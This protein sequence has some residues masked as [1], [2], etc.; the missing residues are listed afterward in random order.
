MKNIFCILLLVISAFQI[1]AE[2]IISNETLFSI[3]NEAYKNEAYSDALESYQELMDNGKSSFELYYNTGNCHF[4]LGN[5]VEAVW[6]YEMAKRITPNN[7][8]VQANIALV[9]RQFVD[10]IKALPGIPLSIW[11]NGFI[12][13]NGANFW[14]ALSLLS[15][16]GCILF[17]ISLWINNPVKY[18]LKYLSLAT[19]IVGLFSFFIAMAV[20]HHFENAQDAI[21][22][23][24]NADVLSEPSSNALELFT[25]HAG[26]K[27]EVLEQNKNWSRIK[28]ASGELGWMKNEEMRLVQ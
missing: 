21:L 6:H 24:S 19:V 2:D 28:I 25:I 26:L 11:W 3:A 16:L 18:V 14:Y 27:M 7:E 10:E 1:S 20:Q 15:L 9:N 4:R 22:L 13:G 17:A 23:S 8:D 12:Y 5:Y